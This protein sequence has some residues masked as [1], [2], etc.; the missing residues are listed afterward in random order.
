MLEISASQAPRLLSAPITLFN[1]S[2]LVTDRNAARGCFGG[3]CEGLGKRDSGCGRHP[4]DRAG[5]SGGP[6]PAARA[7]AD[8][9]ASAVRLALRGFARRL[10][11][12]PERRH[13][14]RSLPVL[15]VSANIFQILPHLEGYLP[16][17]AVAYND[18]FIV[19]LSVFWVRL[20]LLKSGDGELGASAGLTI[21]ETAAAAYGGVRLPTAAPDW[22]V[23]ATLGARYFNVNGSLELQ[24]PL[25]GYSRF[26]SQ[27]RSWADPFAG[28][29]ARHRIDDKWFIDFEADAGGWSGS[30]TALAFGAVGYKWNQSLT[31]SVGY[32]VLYEYYQ[33][34]ANSGIRPAE[35]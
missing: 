24:V 16:A 35:L 17:S 15:P 32:R 7:S 23:Y 3:A 9:D 31:S 19:G 18:N 27:S 33:G 28:V 10:G 8:S 21:N 14:I 4:L 29:T 12:E 30:A 34:A 6:R 22:S 20:G 1:N 2:R 11:A 13:G 5:L 25:G 26:A